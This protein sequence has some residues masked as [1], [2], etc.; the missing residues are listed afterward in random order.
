MAQEILK[1]TELPYGGEET[2]TKEVIGDYTYVSTTVKIPNLHVDIIKDRINAIDSH[3]SIK[4]EDE[5][6]FNQIRFLHPNSMPKTKRLELLGEIYDTNYELFESGITESLID[7][8][9]WWILDEPF[10]FMKDG[11]SID[12]VTFFRKYE[13][14][15][16]FTAIIEY[17]N[18]EFYNKFGAF[19]RVYTC[20]AREYSGLVLLHSLKSM[21]TEKKEKASTFTYIATDDSGFYKIGKSTSPENRLK[22]FRTGNPTIHFV[23]I[24]PHNVER[25]LH[26]K[27]ESYRVN[28]EWFNL[29]KEEVEAIAKEFDV[30]LNF[31][32]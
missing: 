27:Y 21:I 8:L 23:C 13:N 30:K 5:N 4:I 12:G 31:N 25:I 9:E 2:I 22:T 26:T 19:V 3:I 20:A 10:Y 28:G 17:I 16:A 15:N 1:K 29:P 32:K 7:D 6:L 11:V 14:P 24:I 18:P